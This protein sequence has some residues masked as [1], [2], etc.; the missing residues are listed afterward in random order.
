MQGIR[1]WG[2]RI[3]TSGWRNQNP[4][5]YHLATPQRAARLG[6]PGGKRAD[7]SS[8]CPAP[9]WA[10]PDEICSRRR[11]A[12][13]RLTRSTRNNHFGRVTQPSVQKGPDFVSTRR[14]GPTIRNRHSCLVDASSARLL[15]RRSLQRGH[16]RRTIAVCRTGPGAQL[17]Q[18]ASRRSHLAS[19]RGDPDRMARRLSEICPA[20]PVR[21]L[22]PLRL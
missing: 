22:D 6:G 15:Q 20:R 16:C 1:G 12:R 19:V 9:Q 10:E 11:G 7:N 14:R 5:P 13:T 17:E 4:L 3:R 2:G 8:G 18:N 21:R